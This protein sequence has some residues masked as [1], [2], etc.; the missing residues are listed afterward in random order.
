MTSEPLEQASL[1]I[2]LDTSLE[3]KIFYKGNPGLILP[4][5]GALRQAESYLEY[6]LVAR[7]NL[8]HPSENSKH[9]EP[10]RVTRDEALTRY[11]KAMDT[12]RAR[13]GAIAAAPEQASFDLPDLSSL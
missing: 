3:P 11:Y 9:S 7:H 2:A 4:M 10:V 6:E 12:L 1:T 13:I 5:I 8:L